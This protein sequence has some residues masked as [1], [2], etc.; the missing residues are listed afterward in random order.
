MIVAFVIV[1]VLVRA[2]KADM[3]SAVGPVH[4]G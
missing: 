3:A 2:R 4:A 1:A